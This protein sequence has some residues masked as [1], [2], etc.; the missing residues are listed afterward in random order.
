M[1]RTFYKLDEFDNNE[2]W[3]SVFQSIHASSICII[4]N[5][6]TS[7]I[8]ISPLLLVVKQ[9]SFRRWYERKYFTDRVFR[10]NC[11]F[12][13]QFAATPPSPTSLQETFKALNV[14]GVYSHS[15]WLV[16]F[17]TTNSNRV[18]ARERWQTFENSW[19]NTKYLMNT[20]YYL[21]LCKLIDQS[22]V[23]NSLF[24]FLNL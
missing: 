12:F 15:Y 13:S 22:R 7:N 24:A 2:F 19:K 14:M 10:K 4:N 21:Q 17:C 16:I 20:L 18:L 8:N 3:T 9:K 6:A 5:A 11:G 1:H 23:L